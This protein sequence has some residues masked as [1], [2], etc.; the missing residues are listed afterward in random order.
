MSVESGGAPSEDRSMAE[1]LRDAGRDVFAYLYESFAGPLFDYCAGILGDPWAAAEVVQDSLVAV[2][3]QMNKLPD[4]DQVRLWLYSSARQ[5]CLGRLP[6]HQLAS[7][8][9]TVTLDEFI[10]EQAGSTD[11]YPDAGTVATER[12]KLRIVS[13]ALDS[14][15][16]RDREVVSLAYRHGIAEADLAAVLGVNGRRANAL[17]SGAGTEFRASATV[18]AVLRAGRPGCQVLEATAVQ[19]DHAKALLTPKVR[20][21]LVHHV[22]HCASCAQRRGDRDFDPEMVTAIPFASPPVNLGMRISR[23]ATALGTYRTE[24][25]SRSLKGGTSR[26]TKSGARRGVSR[27][28][29]A[30]VAIAVFIVPGMLLFHVVA[31][32]FPGPTPVTVAAASAQTTAQAGSALSSPAAALPTLA[33][34][35]RSHQPVLGPLPGLLGPTP[36]GVLPTPSGR[37]GSASPGSPHPQP[38]PPPSAGSP[39]PNPPPASPTPNPTT[40]PVTTPPPTTPPPTTPPPTTPP[41]TTPPATPSPDPPPASPDPSGTDSPS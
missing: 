32:S 12:E 30:P 33:R 20:K 26:G 11:R 9:E 18:I 17:L 24:A 13:A 25:A 27:T 5:Q 28:V 1:G 34:K 15:P 4:P 23:T 16:D 29:V 37:G 6:G 3:A 21:R 38:N 31:A 10:G 14:L 8:P 40:P 2:D 22:G 41:P 7:R 36:L 39:S 19:G 35:T